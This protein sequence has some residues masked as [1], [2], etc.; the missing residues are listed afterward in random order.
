MDPIDAIVVGAGFGG[1]AA[2]YEL[3]HAGF[4]VQCYERES[5]PGGVWKENRYPGARC[6]SGM[7]DYQFSY[8]STLE[9]FTWSSKFPDRQEILRYFN[10][11]IERLDLINDVIFN[12]TLVKAIWDDVACQWT[13]SFEG[14][15]DVTCKWFIPAFGYASKSYMPKY[16]GIATFHGAL[17]HTAQWPDD[18]DPV[19]KRVAIIGT[20]ASGVQVVQ[21][22]AS[23]T[24][25]LTV[26]QKSPNTAL[27]MPSLSWPVDEQKIVNNTAE[28][29]TGFSVRHSNNQFGAF[30]G[31]PAPRLFYDDTPSER[32]MFYAEMWKAGFG[33]WL[34]NY[35]ET[36]LEDEPNREAYE[37]WAKRTRTRVEDPVKRDILA[38]LTPRYPFGSK[39]PSLELTYYE[40]FNSPHVDIVD[41]SKDPIV[42]IIETGIVTK[43]VTTDFDII[44]FATGFDAFTGGLTS[45]DIVGRNGKLLR[46][47]WAD[48]V[49]SHL[50]IACHGFPNMLY[51]YGPQ[52]P[53]PLC[54]GPTCCQPQAKWIAT[55]LTDMRRIKALAFEATPEVERTWK[56]RL[57][58]DWQSK[59]FSKAN[60]Y[61][62]GANIPGKVIEP[63]MWACGV[64]KYFEALE[65]CR[66]RNWEGFQ[67]SL[68][69]S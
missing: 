68:E 25:Q 8:T 51:I 29:R 45:I 54:S 27:P 3:K 11:S 44:V 58:E 46:D 65:K 41:I 66:A 10:H 9:D 47:Y 39:R 67:I 7:P 50:G 57:V 34:L 63:L 5:G 40:A 56:R 15:K 26:Y 33:F 32:E 61:Y 22:I 49:L 52:S 13:L 20:G 64:D 53:G 55:M 69:S 2:T 1:I 16:Q 36:L 42:E 59:V 38:P 28:I 14:K 6:D 17:F 24:K 23:K 4:D 21:T 37:Y 43:N 30:P 62:Q 12:S 18:I 35:K 48:G 19:N 60:S 31:L